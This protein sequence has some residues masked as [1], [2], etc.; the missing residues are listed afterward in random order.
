M[1]L[2]EGWGLGGSTAPAST[3]KIYHTRSPPPPFP[4]RGARLALA[5][6]QVSRDSRYARRPPHTHTSPRQRRQARPGQ[7]A[8]QQRQ[9]IRL[10]VG[11]VRRGRAAPAAP[12]R[13][14]ARDQQ[15]GVEARG[16]RGGAGQGQAVAKFDLGEGEGEGQQCV[17][18]TTSAS[19]CT[20]KSKCAQGQPGAKLDWEAP[21]SPPRCAHRR[22]AHPLT[23]P[24]LPPPPTRSR[25]SSSASPC[26]PMSSS[27]V[28]AAMRPAAS[29]WGPCL[30]SG[31]VSLSIPM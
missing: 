31:A 21:S 3:H 4:G 28:D 1:Q 26:T 7:L 23:E 6:S 11:A 13:Q 24:P 5:S 17:W 20:S 18:V 15:V 30:P 19:L 8:G 29:R 27:G 10:L 16:V 25:S 12:G 22:A 14:S 2:T 9:H